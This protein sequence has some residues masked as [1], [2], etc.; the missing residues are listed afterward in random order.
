MERKKEIELFLRWRDYSDQQARNELWKAVS[1][2]IKGMRGVMADILGVYDDKML[3]VALDEIEKQTYLEVERKL[4]KFDP[5]RDVKFTTY[6]AGFAKNIARR[7]R[8]KKG[9]VLL[10]FSDEADLDPKRYLRT[11]PQLADE[12]PHEGPITDEN[13]RLLTKAISELPEE[14][15]RPLRTVFCLREGYRPDQIQKGRLVPGIKMTEKKIAIQY[16]FTRSWVNKK[17]TEA[18]SILAKKL[19]KKL[20]EREFGAADQGE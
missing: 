11:F 19:R 2:S 3:N 5:D 15:N 6:C 17:Y 18:K 12:L 10:P 14:P 13:L 4:N 8:A 16:G 7:I 9:T 1:D 20:D